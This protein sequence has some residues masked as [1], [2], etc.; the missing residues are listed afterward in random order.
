MVV[1]ETRT[2]TIWVDE[3]LP[4]VSDADL[5]AATAE[6]ARRMDW[7]LALKRVRQWVDI[8]R[9]SDQELVAWLEVCVPLDEG[10][11]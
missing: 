7:G 5:R 6:F 10:D 9:I 11:A 4:P 3:P 2:E 1:S 8:D